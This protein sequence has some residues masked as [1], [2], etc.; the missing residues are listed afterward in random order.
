MGSLKMSNNFYDN[1]HP[2]QP[3]FTY[4]NIGVAFLNGFF[5]TLFIEAILG[6]WLDL[7][8]W[9]WLFYVADFEMNQL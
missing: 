4:Q 5:P 7:G 3:F 8:S 1:T 2:S 6:A 9:H